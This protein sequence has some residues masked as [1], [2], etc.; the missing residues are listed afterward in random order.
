MF[1]IIA[2]CPEG[3]GDGPEIGDR[4]MVHTILHAPKRGCETKRLGQRIGWKLPHIVIDKMT[5]AECRE[6]VKAAGYTPR[7]TI[8]LFPMEKHKGKGE[9]REKKGG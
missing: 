9:M 6:R 3:R 7:H 2:G 5:I 4:V 1:A 8:I